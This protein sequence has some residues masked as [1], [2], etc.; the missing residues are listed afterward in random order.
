MR[1]CQ[2]L[3]HVTIP[4]IISSACHSFTL[5]L[6]ARNN[7]S[8][9][10]IYSMP[11]LGEVNI[12]YVT[13]VAPILPTITTSALSQSP[14]TT[15][16]IDFY[17]HLAPVK[18]F[19]KYLKTVKATSHTN[20]SPQ[21]I[22]NKEPETGENI[23]VFTLDDFDLPFKAIQ[24]ELP[25]LKSDHSWKIHS[26][27]PLRPT[28][29]DHFKE[30]EINTYK[31]VPLLTPN[32]ENLIKF[33]DKLHN[34]IQFQRVPSSKDVSSGPF[35]VSVL[36]H[37]TVRKVPISQ[38][39]HLDLFLPNHDHRK[40][41]NDII[42]LPNF[43]TDSK[44]DFSIYSKKP[45]VTYFEPDF[46][47]KSTNNIGPTILP[48]SISYSQLRDDSKTGARKHVTIFRTKDLKQQ[49]SNNNVIHN[50]AL[51]S[52]NSKIQE[53]TKAPNPYE[54]VLYRV[55]PNARAQLKPTYNQNVKAL[56]TKTYSSLDLERLLSQME[57]ESEV[58]RNLGRSADKNKDVAGQ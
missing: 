2:M 19:P 12:N 40:F 53:L 45:I 18:S 8:T 17:R 13:P 35:K 9:L 21:N 25:L 27:T 55:M 38:V 57:V 20:N 4:F 49:K 44:S 24:A 42:S 31:G 32:Q 6:T 5:L 16:S 36:N 3:L 29:N 48:N 43:D 39:D 37:D 47:N 58:N 1:S 7:E 30:N 46:S 56:T 23:T 28:L 26:K 22:M 33:D 52:L 54:T 10:Q 14:I 41:S 11:T 51:W 50:K 15:D 34:T